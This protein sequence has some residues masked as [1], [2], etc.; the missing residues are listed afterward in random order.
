VHDAGAVFT[1][2]I[3]GTTLTVTAVASGLLS[4]G[5]EIITAGL[6][7]GTRI[8]AHLSGVRGGVGTYTVSASQ[9]VSSQSMT[10]ERPYYLQFSNSTTTVG[11]NFN[12]GDSITGGTMASS[13]LLMS[14]IENQAVAGGTGL[15]LG[16][17]YSLTPVI[18]AAANTAP[19]T[20]IRTFW[21]YITDKGMIWSTTNSTTY[22]NGWG[23]TYTNALLQSGPWMFG[24]YTRYDGFN[25]DDTGILPVM[26]TVPRASG[27]GYGRATDYTTINNPNYTTDQTTIPFKVYNI[28]EASPQV[29]SNWPI[30][31][32]PN[33]GY[34]VAGG[35]NGQRGMT[36]R[37][38]VDTTSAATAQY[39]KELTVAAA[40]RY[41]TVNL[42]STGFSLLPIGWEHL[43][44]GNHGGDM[45][46]QSGFYIF[47]G[48]YQPGDTFGLNGKVWTVWPIFSGFAARIGIAVPKE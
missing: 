40:E 29:G 43:M 24:Q 12:I 45:S 32:F 27:E 13:Q 35:S 46:D 10:S 37:S 38:T 47:N 28:I 16:N 19:A 7:A 23:P 48:D 1:G 18:L 2:S 30:T 26:F 14:A 21:M 31:Y 42:A 6:T 41:P 15:T 17:G 3:A 9:T 33:V 25:N 22:A 44:R 34:T 39:G 5:Q 11:M 36:F 4:V 20:A 8:T